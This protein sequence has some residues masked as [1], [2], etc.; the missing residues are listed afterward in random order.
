[1][2]PVGRRSSRTNEGYT[3]L[4]RW[5]DFQKSIIALI[6]EDGGKMK[7]DIVVIGNLIA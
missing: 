2:S 1:M 7:R 6:N 5:L 4:F 3:G